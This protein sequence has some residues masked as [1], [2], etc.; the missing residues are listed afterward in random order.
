[1]VQATDGSLYLSEWG[2]EQFFGPNTD[3]GIYRIEYRGA[4]SNQ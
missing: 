4:G 2:T 3:S 1:M